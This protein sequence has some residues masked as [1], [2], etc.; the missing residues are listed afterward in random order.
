MVTSVCSSDVQSGQTCAACSRHTQFRQE[1]QEHVVLRSSFQWQK[2]HRPCGFLWFFGDWLV[3]DFLEIVPEDFLVLA[4]DRFAP[5]AAAG[6]DVAVNLF[7]L[8]PVL[9]SHVV[10]CWMC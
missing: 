8:P 3:V 1:T 5:E 9:P 6:L 10:F 7:L 4:A 2:Q